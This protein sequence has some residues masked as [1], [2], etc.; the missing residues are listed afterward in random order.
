MSVEEKKAVKFESARRQRGKR[1]A[2]ALEQFANQKQNIADLQS[3]VILPAK[4]LLP[5]L[6]PEIVGIPQCIR[7]NEIREHLLNNRLEL[8]LNTMDFPMPEH[9]LLNYILVQGGLR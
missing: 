4:A 9:T 1:I 3:Q 8:V 7:F 6:P 5:K 2:S